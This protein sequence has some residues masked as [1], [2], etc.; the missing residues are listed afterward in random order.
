MTGVSRTK[1]VLL[2]LIAAAVWA[3]TF[4]WGGYSLGKV[5]E[6]YLGEL[7]QVV[8][9][10]IVVVVLCVTLVNW[11][12][13]RRK[14]IGRRR[15]R[16]RTGR[17]RKESMSACCARAYYVCRTPK[18]RLPAA[19]AGQQSDGIG[20][21]LDAFGRRSS[22]ASI[23]AHRQAPVE[24]GPTVGATLRV[25][26]QPIKQCRGVNGRQ[27]Q[28]LRVIAEIGRLSPAAC[29]MARRCANRHAAPSAPLVGRLRKVTARRTASR[30][31][32][33]AR[34]ADGSTSDPF[35]APH[36]IEIDGTS[37]LRPICGRPDRRNDRPRQRGRR[38]RPVRRR[39]GSKPHPWPPRARSRGLQPS[40]GTWAS[41]A[42]PIGRE[43]RAYFPVR[44]CFLLGQPMC[45][46]RPGLLRPP[47]RPD[48]AVHRR[49]SQARQIPHAGKD[50]GYPARW[51]HSCCTTRA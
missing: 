19:S 29:H 18:R 4:A 11:F 39:L 25:V 6:T 9:A 31:S 1:F 28:P 34:F 26:V 5:S 48:D 40:K 22:I 7:S 15:R 46:P 42:R 13:Q 20:Q 14:I 47:R 33:Q 43:C 32:A 38:E 44:S 21:S 10:V 41:V 16:G 45:M 49:I 50:K 35:R 2:N 30:W 51:S 12:R 36:A 27:G 8:L 37:R 23:S 17:R 3:N 24:E